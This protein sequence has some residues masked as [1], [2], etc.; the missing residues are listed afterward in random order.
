MRRK[1]STRGPDFK[2]ITFPWKESDD[3]QNN[4]YIRYFQKMINATRKVKL[5]QVI[6]GG[7]CGALSAVKWVI[8]EGLSKED[9]NLDLNHGRVP[10]S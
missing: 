4:K 7:G 2:E 10:Q 5:V 1:W 3:K 9:L 6:M 8:K